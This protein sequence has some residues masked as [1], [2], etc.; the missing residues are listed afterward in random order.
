M[1]LY[2]KL[3]LYIF[4]TSYI[5]VCCDIDFTYYFVVQVGATSQP[6]EDPLPT[7]Y[8]VQPEWSQNQGAGNHCKCACW[9]ILGNIVNSITMK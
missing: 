3:C 5:S 6:P 7:T 4:K 8:P 1:T 9:G 2:R